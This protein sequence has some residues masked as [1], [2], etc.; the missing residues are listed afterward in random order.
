[1]RRNHGLLA[2]T[3]LLLLVGCGG[4]EPSRGGSQEPGGGGGG[5]GGGGDVPGPCRVE[6]SGDSGGQWTLR[7]IEYTYDQAGRVESLVRVYRGISETKRFH[8]DEA[9]R[10]VLRELLYD[11]SEI[12]QRTR[13]THDE[14]GRVL[15]EELDGDGCL[16]GAGEPDTCRPADGRVDSFRR[17]EYDASGR[18]VVEE[19]GRGQA[20]GAA[21]TRTTH[22]WDDAGHQI[23]TE[24]DRGA[25]GRVDERTSRRFDDAGHLVREA[26]DLR[27]DGRDD[28]VTTWTFSDDGLQTAK[29]YDRDADGT[30]D[31]SVRYAYDS[32]GR[33]AEE[34]ESAGDSLR[35]RA[36][37]SYD[38][39]GNLT[40]EEKFYGAGT[41]ADETRVWLY[42]CWD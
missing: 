39:A 42:S 11:G 17:Y 28:R 22:T 7:H 15:T 24:I 40:T 6:V 2:G 8:Y 37:Y 5:G 13:L 33:L 3:T 18:L 34:A 19:S 9:G 10:V 16:A 12:A 29:H 30:P 23:A 41:L 20:D 38:A 4:M 36:V 1:M 25:D 32:A 35:F 21:G 27:A 31:T 26:I 14:A